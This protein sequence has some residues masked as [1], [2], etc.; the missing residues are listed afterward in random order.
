MLAVIADLLG[1][2]SADDRAKLAAI[3]AQGNGAKGGNP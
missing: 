3:L 1:D 2:L